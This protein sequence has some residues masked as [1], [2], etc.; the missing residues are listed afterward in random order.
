MSNNDYNS[1]SGVKLPKQEHPLTEEQANEWLNCADDIKYFIDNHVWIQNPSKGSVLFNY[2]PYQERI[3]DALNE[4]NYLIALLSRQSGKCL[5]HK[6]EIHV[7]SKTTGETKKISIGDFF[8]LCK[9][10]KLDC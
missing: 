9:K 4:N 6:T 2:R 5:Y 10:Q 8:E 3:I 7:K 1:A